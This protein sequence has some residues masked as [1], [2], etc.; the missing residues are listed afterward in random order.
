[1]SATYYTNEDS[2]TC[3]KCGAIVVDFVD[4]E[5]SIWCETCWEARCWSR[6]EDATGRARTLRDEL[7]ALQT[8]LAEAETEVVETCD[9]L[10]LALARHCKPDKLTSPP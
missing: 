4:A 6:Y 1:M 3:E 2:E 5:F 7:V 8:R 10:D 9:E